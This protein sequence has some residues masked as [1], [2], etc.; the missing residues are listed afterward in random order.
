MTRSRPL[1]RRQRASSSGSPAAAAAKPPSSLIE[2]SPVVASWVALVDCTRPPVVGR[3]GAC[4][5]ADTAMTGTQGYP[6]RAPRTVRPASAHRGPRSPRARSASLG[7][8]VADLALLPRLVPVDRQRR[9]AAVDRL[10]RL[11]AVDRL[12]RIRVLGL[13]GR[14][15]RLARL[16]VLGRL[17][18]LGLLGRS[19]GPRVRT[20]PPSAARPPASPWSSR[21]WRSCCSFAGAPGRSA[22]D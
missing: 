20:A 6:R 7:R 4:A 18:V 14:L 5:R 8:A 21:W 3:T 12:D 17:R 16:A 19:R 13:L 1:R 22:S 15:R 11:G 2:T 9:L 10:G